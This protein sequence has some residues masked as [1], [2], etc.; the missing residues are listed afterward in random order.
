MDLGTGDAASS[1]GRAAWE[2]EQLACR[3][4][5]VLAGASL[6]GWTLEQSGEFRRVQAVR[7]PPVRW[8]RL[9]VSHVRS[10]LSEHAAEAWMPGRRFAGM[11]PAVLLPSEQVRDRT[12]RLSVLVAIDCS[13]SVA[14]KLLDQLIAAA[15]SLPRDRVDL[16]AITFDVN[17]YPLDLADP[18][19]HPRGGGGTSFVCIEQF[20]QDLPSYPDMVAVLT[21][22]AGQP[23]EP[24]HPGRW[25]WLLTPE[26][27]IAYVKGIGRLADIVL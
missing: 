19:S 8:D 10:R 17:A 11:Y 25:L 1:T 14:P 16:T 7:A 3:L 4:D 23:P 27:T 21:D 6:H 20:A 5:G 26:S 9:L 15:R 12:D 24:K 18:D 13:G 22:G 2:R